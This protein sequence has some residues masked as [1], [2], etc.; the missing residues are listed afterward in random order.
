MAWVAMIDLVQ[1]VANE[2]YFYEIKSSQTF[3]AKFF[4][5]IKNVSKIFGD[6][7]TKSAVIYD[8][9]ETIKSEVNGLYNFK[10]IP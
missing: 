3:N 10:N 5:N 4:D 6:R 7:V 2:L 1:T 9:K 8:G